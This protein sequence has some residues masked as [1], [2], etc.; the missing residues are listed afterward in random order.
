MST[1]HDFLRGTIDK[2]EIPS[3]TY[4]I[5]TSAQILE[6]GTLGQLGQGRAAVREDT[7]YDLASVTKPIVALAAM[8]LLQNG[9][10]A[11]DDTVATYLDEYR[12]TT[13][14]DITI[15]QLLTH[16]SKIYGCVPLYKTAHTKEELL[17]AIVDMPDRE[18]NDVL[19]S[20]QGIIVLGCIIEKICGKPLDQVLKE[21]IFEPLAMNTTMF[22]PPERLFGNIASTEYCQWR[23]RMIIGEVHDENA[24]VLGGVCGHAGLFSNIFDLA[25]LCVAMLTA[26]T[27]R[28]DSF[29]SPAV[30]KLMTQNHTADL[31]LA[32]GLGWQAKDKHGS[33]AGDLFSET[34]YGHTGFTGTSVWIDP[35]RD[36]YAVLLTN[37]VHPSRANEHIFKIRRKFHN[38]A[39][40]LSES[41]AIG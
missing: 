13:K 16:T 17:E 1:I 32:R 2:G 18:K 41:Q 8:K 25:K 35:S 3:A 27:A 34:S 28:G 30:C 19:Y 40:I 11:L 4:I 6:K 23:Q 21:M 31:N 9:Q 12:N 14:S 38:L 15:Y 22:N 39:V 10:I 36:L 29:L 37:R 20:S 7:L 5:G 33:P 26:K 24:V